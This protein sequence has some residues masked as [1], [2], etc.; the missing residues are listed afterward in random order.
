VAVLEVS[1]LLARTRLTDAAAAEGWDVSRDAAAAPELVVVDLDAPNALDRARAW[2]S[3]DVRVV[4]FVSHVD[5]ATREAAIALGVE[6][7]TRGAAAAGARDIFRA[8]TMKP[9]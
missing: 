5:A 9:S 1:D 8:G 3:R 4:G 2:R 6:V 7:M